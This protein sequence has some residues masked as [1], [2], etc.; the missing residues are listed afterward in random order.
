MSRLRTLQPAL[1]A[2]LAQFL[3]CVVG[4]A[5]AQLQAVRPDQSAVPPGPPTY[6]DGVWRSTDGR[7]FKVEGGRLIALT[8]YV[9]VLWQVKKG[10]VIVADMEQVGPRSFTGH[11]VGWNIRW[12][13]EIDDQARLQATWHGLLGP[14]SISFTAESLAN[15][16]WFQ[17]A[18][19]GY[20][21]AYPLPVYVQPG[22]PPPAYT[23]PR[24]GYRPPPGYAQP[25]YGQPAHA[26]P[27]GGCAHT[28][29]DA[30]RG[31]YA[32]VQ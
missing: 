16:A 18:T 2:L 24:Q 27:A 20:Q 11:D 29:Y 21:Q 22:Y 26:P 5:Q 8:D 12:T 7:R 3:P 17:Q 19:A 13:G 31:H 28:V 10:M 25:G 14:V 9:D 15:L 1:H 23:A 4:N 30:S 32:C 6:L